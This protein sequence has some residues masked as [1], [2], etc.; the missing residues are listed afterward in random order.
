[1]ATFVCLTDIKVA[2]GLD[3]KSNTCDEGQEDIPEKSTDASSRCEVSKSSLKQ[4]DILGKWEKKHLSNEELNK[5]LL[6][7]L[8]RTLEK[9]GAVI[10]SPLSPHDKSLTRTDSQNLKEMAS[11]KRLAIQGATQMLKWAKR[12]GK[13]FEASLTKMG[14]ELVMY[15]SDDFSF[16]MA[17]CTLF[18]Q[19]CNADSTNLALD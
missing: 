18:P 7:H 9:G 11:A 14:C 6:K 2:L 19:V 16:F 4:E 1:M 5:L 13:N 10:V 12:T 8:R 15:D 17:I 3:S